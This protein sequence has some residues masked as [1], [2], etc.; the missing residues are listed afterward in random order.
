MKVNKICHYQI[1]D[2]S[3]RFINTVQEISFRHNQMQLACRLFTHGLEPC[4]SDESKSP[5]TVPETD[6][7]EPS[8]TLLSREGL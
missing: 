6:D 7:A 1:A 5:V 2:S 8:L 4:S 3:V